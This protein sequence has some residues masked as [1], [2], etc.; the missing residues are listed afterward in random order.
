MGLIRLRATQ[1]TQEIMNSGDVYDF[2]ITGGRL[3]LFVFGQPKVQWSN[4]VARCVDNVN[5]ALY[6]DGV[7]DY[8]QIGNVSAL[9]LL[10]R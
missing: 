7:E 1:G 6:L 4:L 8:V 9:G 5:V 3:G 10:E 2:S